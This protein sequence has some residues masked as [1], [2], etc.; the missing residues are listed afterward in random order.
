MAPRPSLALKLVLALLSP[1][2]AIAAGSACLLCAP[3]APPPASGRA[4]TPI[5]VEIGAGLDFDR[6]T[7]T[8]P[9]GGSVDLGPD[10][11][12]SF[13]G[14]LAGLGGLAM[15]G[16]ATVRG[17]PGRAVRI[18]LPGSIILHGSTGSSARISRLVTDLPPA[19]RLGPD[20]ALRFS[21][22][23]RLDVSG[24][25]DGDYRGRIAITVDYQ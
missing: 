19:P 11:S 20:G 17:E 18:E 8:A 3:S 2:P 21:F 4:E 5:A 23:G 9:G 10:G 14:A 7:V 25:A 15:V 16:T 12:R 1:S 13:S 24:E 6:V 22:G